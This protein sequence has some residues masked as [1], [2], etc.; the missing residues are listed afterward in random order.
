MG[1]R[2]EVQSYYANCGVAGETPEESIRLQNMRL[3]DSPS[4]LKLVAQSFVSVPSNAVQSPQNIKN[5]TWDLS[6]QE[7]LELPTGMLHSIDL[8]VSH[9]KL[10]KRICLDRHD[11]LRN[12]EKL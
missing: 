11:R 5:K 2:S 4:D 6:Q 8:Q 1:K 10:G 3:A 9:I 7:L 12:S